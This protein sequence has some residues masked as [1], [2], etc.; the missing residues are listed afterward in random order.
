[1]AAF[2]HLC[3]AK[4]SGAPLIPCT[5]D[6]AVHKLDCTSTHHDSSDQLF[7]KFFKLSS[8]PKNSVPPIGVPPPTRLRGILKS[9]GNPQ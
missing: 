9:G 1:M 3:L 4:D 5:S 8:P 6:V 2:I 7:L